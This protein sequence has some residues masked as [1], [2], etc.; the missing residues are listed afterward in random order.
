MALTAV[1]EA[2]LRKLRSTDQRRLAA[3]TRSFEGRLAEAYEQ[4]NDS[5]R[6]ATRA[7]SKAVELEHLAQELQSKNSKL[8][9]RERQAVKDLQQLA[10]HVLSLHADA[11]TRLDATSAAIFARRGWNTRAARP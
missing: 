3:V 8:L 11:N 2:A 4:L 7:T 10:V 6:T 1:Y 9:L 5:A